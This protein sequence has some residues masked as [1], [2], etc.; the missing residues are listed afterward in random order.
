M[1]LTAEE[2]FQIGLEKTAPQTQIAA[3]QS[4]RTAAII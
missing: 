1:A 4:S 2:W 3:A